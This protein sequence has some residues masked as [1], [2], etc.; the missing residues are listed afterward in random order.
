MDSQSDHAL[1][2]FDGQVQ[3]YE[4]S[5][6]SES[7]FVVVSEHEM[8]FHRGDRILTRRLVNRANRLSFAR[9]DETFVVK[10]ALLPVKPNFDDAHKLAA[11][12]AILNSSLMSFLYLSRSTAAVKDDFR[13]VTLSGL[14]ELPIIFPDE[15][16]MVELA[17]L[18][19]S[20]E[21]QD[22]NVADLERRID[23]II[24]RTYDV[25]ADEQEAIATWLA[26]SG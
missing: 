14:R 23:A 6:P 11:L 3:R 5:A 7:K 22:S 1:T 16:T 13:Q 12:L 2:F 9:T 4:V 10:E 25:T 21:K 8:P 19:S 20:R 17:Q 24:Y 26:R 15:K 18:V